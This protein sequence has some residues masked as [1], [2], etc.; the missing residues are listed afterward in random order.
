MNRRKKTKINVI[1]SLLHQVVVF[2]CGLI[3][4]R[5][6]LRAFGSS[7]NG[8]IS[9][10]TQ[11]MSMVSFLTL[12]VAG[13]LRAELYKSLAEGDN[14][15]TSRTM[16]AAEKYMRKVGA[17][18]LVY[19][20]ILMIVFPYISNT[21][22]SGRECAIII[23]IVS[24]DTFAL[25]FFGTANYSLITAD[26]KVYIKSLLASAVSILNTLMVALIIF[27]GGNIFQVKGASALVYTITPIGIALYVKNHYRIDRKCEP[28]KNALRKKN[29]AAVHSI[30]NIVH[31]NTDVLILTV[32]L[33]IKYVSVYIIYY[34]IVGKIKTL[35]K[36]ATTG[37][38]AALGNMWAK[39]EIEALQKTFRIYEYGIS[40]FVV[41][42]FSCIGVLLVPFIELYTSKVTDINYLRPGFALLITVAEALFCVRQPYRS[43][44]HATGF[45]KET[46]NAAIIE[47]T[48]NFGVSVS[49][50]SLLGLNGVVIG[51]LVANLYRTLSYARFV[52]ESV[53]QRDFKSVLYRMLWAAAGMGTSIVVASK[54]VELIAM[55]GWIGWIVEGFMTFFIA[56]AVLLLFSLSFYKDDMIQILRLLT[57]DR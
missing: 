41:T 52:S 36:E 18:T 45:F 16:K 40:A 32:F 24:I 14:D 30:A 34:S 54:A 48:I 4:P 28:N 1:T 44:V 17:A 9:S 27:K 55:A 19:A 5:L 8:V 22:I 31:D 53:L 25:Y 10:A 35:I 12:G 42:V 57:R 7:Y 50:V 56:V 6:I 2:I 20:A 39:N 49:L 21:S 33:D 37:I 26:Q 29:D 47:A 51:T 11:L 15:M 43:L 46:R 23:G 3:T 13:A 38:E